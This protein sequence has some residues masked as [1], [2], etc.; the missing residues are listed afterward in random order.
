MMQ[1]E[2]SADRDLVTFAL[3][4]QQQSDSLPELKRLLETPNGIKRIAL[5][6]KLWIEKRSPSLRIL[7]NVTRRSRI[8]RHTSVNGYAESGN[9]SD[10]N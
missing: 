8:V 9:H 10:R 3:I 6:L 5:D 4:G 2:T 1:I 7:K